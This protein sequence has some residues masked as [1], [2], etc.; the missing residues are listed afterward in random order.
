MKIM[1]NIAEHFCSASATETGRKEEGLGDTPSLAIAD[2]LINGMLTVEQVNT[3]L[4]RVAYLHG[5]SQ[6]C[7]GCGN[8]AYECSCDGSQRKHARVAR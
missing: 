7:Q 8:F 1:L 2:L 3:A 5:V 4:V 6:G